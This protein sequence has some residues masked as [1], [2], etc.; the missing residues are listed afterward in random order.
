[1]RVGFGMTTSAPLF[2]EMM[3]FFYSGLIKMSST[4]PP[5]GFY[6]L[7]QQGPKDPELHRHLRDIG[8]DQTIRL[9]SDDRVKRLRQARQ[10]AARLQRRQTSDEA[11]SMFSFFRDNTADL[12]SLFRHAYS[13][14]SKVGVLDERHATRQQFSAK[15]KKYW[16]LLQKLYVVW[17]DIYQT[18]SKNPSTTQQLVKKVDKMTETFFDKLIDLNKQMCTTLDQL[19][20]MK[21]SSRGGA[22]QTLRQFLR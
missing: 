20:A 15:A 18:L 14:E 12:L 10:H 9:Q 7:F 6:Q 8:I 4:D 11:K 22:A 2:N 17:E 3:I 1:M 19:D 16:T 13:I 21:P 5:Q